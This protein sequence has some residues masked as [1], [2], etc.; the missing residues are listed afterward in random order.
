[1]KTLN[2]LFLFLFVTAYGQK[3]P[4]I[5]GPCPINVGQQVTYSVPSNIAQCAECFDWDINNTDSSVSGNVQIVGSDQNNTVTI[6]GLSAGSFTL[7]VTYFNETG[8]HVLELGC[9]VVII[10]T[11]TLPSPSFNFYKVFQDSYWLAAVTTHPSYTYSWTVTY[12]NG[13]VHNATGANAY[14]IPFCNDGFSIL[15]ITL[16]ISDGFCSKSTTQ[17]MGYGKNCILSRVSL[18]SNP[19]KDKL[20]LNFDSELQFVGKI[21]SLS[22]EE[23]LSF[24]ERNVNQTDVSKL[25]KSS[26]YI[27][28]IYDLEGNEIVSEKIMK[29]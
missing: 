8:C 23:L 7:K 29:E 11:C 20:E 26:L 27:I 4:A 13:Q 3:A 6:Q 28:K 17:N 24:N 22:G 16:T 15:T 12:Y 14:N 18:S 5:S 21:V 25:K 1:M 10:E 19:I 9:T 2:L